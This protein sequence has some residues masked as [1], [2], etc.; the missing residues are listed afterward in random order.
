AELKKAGADRYLLREETYD[1][2]HYR[3]L[4]PESMDFE[5]RIQCLKNLKD[6]DYDC[7]A[8]FMVGSPFQTERNIAQDL[9]FIEEIKPRMCGI[10]PFVPQ[11]QTEFKNFPAGSADLTCFLISI[12]RIM[13]P[14]LL[15]PATT[16]LGTVEKDGREKGILAGA[17]VVMPNLSPAKAKENYR[18]Y[19]NKLSSG[20]ESA[21]NLSLLEKKLNSIGFKIQISRGDYIKT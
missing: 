16:S 3:K 4:H 7:G 5:N 19:D 8:G 21:E 17:N 6:L 11:S 20:A 15:I 10:G 14:S 18:L 12:L 13:H 2:S 1:Y 9:K